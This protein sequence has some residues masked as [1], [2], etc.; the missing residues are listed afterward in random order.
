MTIMLNI[1]KPEFFPVT[2]LKDKLFSKENVMIKVIF[3]HEMILKEESVN[4]A[5]SGLLWLEQRTNGPV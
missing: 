3:M 5:N 4:E 2:S 1:Y